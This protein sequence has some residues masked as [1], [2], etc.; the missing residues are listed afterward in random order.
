MIKKK[1]INFYTGNEQEKA[2]RC[3]KYFKVTKEYGYIIKKERGCPVRHVLAFGT[4]SFL[5]LYAI[6]T[7]KSLLLIPEG[8]HA[9][10]PHH[11]LSI[12]I[13]QVM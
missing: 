6:K 8:L 4:A 11:V 9:Q 12:G 10:S 2:A 13:Y 3:N 1:G 7:G 5:S